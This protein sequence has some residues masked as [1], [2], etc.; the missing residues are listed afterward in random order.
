MLRFFLIYFFLLL[1]PC[2]VLTQSK[3]TDISK[4]VKDIAKAN[5]FTSASVGY[6]GEKP[7]QY[8]RFEK[9]SKLAS[10]KKLYKLLSNQN[11]VVRAYAL[12]ALIL[13]K[14]KIDAWVLAKN[15]LSDYQ[16]INTIFGCIV[17]TK[18]TGDVFIDRLLPFLIKKQLYVLENL[19]VKKKSKSN[20]NGKYEAEAAHLHSELMRH[21][22]KFLQ[23]GNNF[24]S[25]SQ[26]S[27]FYVALTPK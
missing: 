6:G 2:A 3:S 7:D 19:S 18:F 24:P 12:E 26:P 25:S 20:R 23:S 1:T 4:L 16:K 22:L 10:N 13:R 15:A 9:L 5:V 14:A 21:R 17:S 8:K 11:S 27:H